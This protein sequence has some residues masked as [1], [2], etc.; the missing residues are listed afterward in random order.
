MKFFWD[1][2]KGLNADIERHREKEKELEARIAELEGL[3]DKMSIASL[4]VYRN[5]LCQLQQSKADV[6]TK[7][8]KK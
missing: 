4:R 8:G 5:F 7:I 1:K 6:V 3:D 2:A